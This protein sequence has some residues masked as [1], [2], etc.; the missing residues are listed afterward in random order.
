LDSVGTT[1]EDTNHETNTITTSNAMNA[2]QTEGKKTMIARVINIWT[3]IPEPTTEDWR[4]VTNTGHDLSRIK[5]ALETGL[6]P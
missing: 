2:Q 4:D 1:K 6:T 3:T 5:T